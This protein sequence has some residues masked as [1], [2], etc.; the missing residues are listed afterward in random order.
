MFSFYFYLMFLKSPQTPKNVKGTQNVL[1]KIKTSIKLFI[2]NKP[3]SFLL[4]SQSR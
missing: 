2:K 1:T 4:T 3:L